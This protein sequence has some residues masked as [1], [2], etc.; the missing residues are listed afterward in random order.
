MVETVA[1]FEDTVAT[2]DV[3]GGSLTLSD[4]TIIC[5]SDATQIKYE[6]GDTDRLPSL[7]AV[8]D[9]LLAGTTV[10]TAGEGV[11]KQK[12]P[13]KLEALHIVFEI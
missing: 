4:G 6:E 1:G 9:A 11:V 7:Q 5:I 8:A 10:Y 3:D 2:V 12:E 13:L